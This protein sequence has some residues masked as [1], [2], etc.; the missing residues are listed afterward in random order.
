MIKSAKFE[1]CIRDSLIR[2][3]T[4]LMNFILDFTIYIWLPF[5]KV[6]IIDILCIPVIYFRDQNHIK[7]L[8]FD[9]AHGKEKS[10]VFFISFYLSIFYLFINLFIFIY[11]LNFFFYK[12]VLKIC[13]QI[14][15]RKQ[16]NVTR[17]DIK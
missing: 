14:A 3:F 5:Q 15:E 13:E 4:V 1:L 17:I 9:L 2:E 16:Q 10:W 8:I 12:S 6:D 11:L 7:I